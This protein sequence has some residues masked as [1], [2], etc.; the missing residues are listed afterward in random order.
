MKTLRSL[1]VLQ[2][3]DSLGMGGAETWLMSVLRCWT[4]TGAVKMDFLLTGKEPGVYDNEAKSLGAVLHRIPFG[5]KHLLSFARDFRRLLR[6]ERYDA[7]HD[8]SDYSS[9]LHYALGL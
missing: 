9:G 4:A 8:H 6:T 3:L 5:R 7:I 1:R 2:V